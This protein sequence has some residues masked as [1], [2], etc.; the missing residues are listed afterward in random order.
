MIAE[1]AKGFRG[2][3]CVWCGEP[4]AVSG[5]AAN[6]RNNFEAEE[7]TPRSFISRCKL[8]EC[9]NIYSITDIRTYDGEPRKR[10]WRAQ[11]AGA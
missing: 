2:V 6:L 10:T 4:I 5:K 9:E 8:C 7:T 11:R 1:L 3:A